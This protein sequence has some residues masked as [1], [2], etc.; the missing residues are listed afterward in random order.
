MSAADARLA[1]SIGAEDSGEP[2]VEWVW[3]YA[4]TNAP[5]IL[6]CPP[7]LHLESRY[8]LPVLAALLRVNPYF[9]Y[10]AGDAIADIEDEFGLD[11]IKVED[12]TEVHSLVVQQ[13]I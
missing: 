6:E 2:I 12:F 10:N 11:E 3:F 8:T 9:L 5:A 1:A 4:N 13:G 7:L